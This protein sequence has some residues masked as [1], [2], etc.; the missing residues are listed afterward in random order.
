M[1]IT[2]STVALITGASSGIG[3]ALAIRMAAKG[4]RVAIAAR[5]R[6]RLEIVAENI[7]AAGGTPLILEADLTI[8][9][10]RHSGKQ[11]RPRQHGF[12]RRHL[13]GPA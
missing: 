11:C 8:E 1:T 6:D 3:A 10:D 2:S 7:R 12:R 5:R 9:S 4:A 13:D